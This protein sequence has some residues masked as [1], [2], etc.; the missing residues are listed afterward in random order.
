[1]GDVGYHKNPI[2]AMGINDA[3][4]RRK[5]VADAPDDHFSGQRPFDE[6]MSSYQ[7]TRD[8]EAGPVYEF[9]DQFATME[10]SSPPRTS[11][12]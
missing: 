9:T 5:L 2:T 4:P 1:M 11:G 3:L 12:R 10:C 6:G 7:Q 8:L